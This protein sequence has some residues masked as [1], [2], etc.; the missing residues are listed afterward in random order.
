MTVFLLSL[1]LLA[2]GITVMSLVVI[3][4]KRSDFSKFSVGHNRSMKD[5]GIQ[6]AGKEEK[7]LHKKEKNGNSCHCGTT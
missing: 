7:M 6:C 2:V 1:G 3:V 4:R 5:R